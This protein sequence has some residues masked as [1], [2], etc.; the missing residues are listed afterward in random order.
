MTALQRPG[1]RRP[2]AGLPGLP[3]S[4]ARTEDASLLD[5]LAAQLDGSS[6]GAAAAAGAAAQMQRSLRDSGRCEA[7][8]LWLPCAV[9]ASLKPGRS[10]KERA[11]LLGC[12]G[13][14]SFLQRCPATLSHSCAAMMS[15]L[16]F[17]RHQMHMRQAELLLCR[18]SAPGRMPG[19][20]A[21]RPAGHMGRA[22][23]HNSS[24]G[25]ICGPAHLVAAHAA[26]MQQ[27]KAAAVSQV[28]LSLADCLWQ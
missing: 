27:S 17:V 5:N 4:A 1:Q 28:C 6:S 2:E 15:A 10:I 19:M 21:R 7:L 12:Q 11:L 18:A 25:N 13:P 16:G 3:G 20:V 26:R 22:T 9:V 8:C 14:G 23:A 24:S